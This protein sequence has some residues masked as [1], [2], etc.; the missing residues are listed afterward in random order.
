MLPIQNPNA[1]EALPAAW[2]DAGTLARETPASTELTG[3]E[4]ELPLLDSVALWPVVLF[5]FLGVAT[6]ITAGLRIPI[7]RASPLILLA[8]LVPVFACLRRAVRTRRLV[9]RT[10]LVLLLPALVAIWIVGWDFSGHAL[11]DTPSYSPDAWAYNA[12]AD[13]LEHFP[14]GQDSGMIAL[15]EFGSKGRDDRFLSSALLALLHHTLSSIFVAN[16][17]FVALCLVGHFHSMFFFTRALLKGWGLPLAAAF[18]S[19][20]I[21]WVCDA[22]M[23]GNY[24]NLL[25][26]TFC[27]A[28]LGIVV[29]LMRREPGTAAARGTSRFHWSVLP[30]STLLAAVIYAYPEGTALLA[31]LAFPLWIA[32]VWDFFSARRSRGPRLLLLVTL[33]GLTLLF[34]LPDLSVFIGFLHNQLNASMNQQALRPG[35]GLLPGLLQARFL[36]SLF[37]LGDE[38][39]GASYNVSHLLLSVLLLGLLLVG[40]SRIARHHRWFPWVGVVVLLMV[41]WMGTIKHYDYGI[42]KLM[43]CSCWWVYPALVAGFWHATGN[44]SARSALPRVIL[45]TL[46]LLGI[47]WE[48]AGNR[49]RRVL[50]PGSYSMNTLLDLKAIPALVKQ[51]P[52]ALDLNNE[53]DE[54]WAVYYLRHLRVL[55]LPGRSSYLDSAA[56]QLAK[57]RDGSLRLAD[58]G[59]MLVS[60]FDDRALWHDARCSLIAVEPIFISSISNPPNG[61][62]HLGTE[63][64]F[65]MGTQPL[66]ITVEASAA[67]SYALQVNR[68][69]FGPSLPGRD[70][71]TMQIHD[72]GPLKT[73]VI[74]V[75]TH[76]IPLQLNQG[77]NIIV[78]HCLD[79]PTVRLQPNGDTRELLLALSVPYVT[80]I[81]NK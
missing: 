54:I 9:V 57:G 3:G 74:D 13:Y 53:L 15:D 41:G 5:A 35:E 6:G 29:R 77:T 7:G 59:Y 73:I 67:G 42:Y 50:P 45:A 1:T 32:F 19:T 79:Q 61:E 33:C 24:D 27:P 44:L 81:G 16:Y 49:D 34:V 52:V 22:V 40:A 68:F 56:G 26:V 39:P 65:W 2:P 70:E 25:F 18:L 20:V 14:R 76:E 64:V 60:G 71:R 21:G 72:A 11:P 37:A 43:F 75:H 4:E 80:I 62:D 58:C 8:A 17:L 46:L 78:L 66:T 23:L 10:W 30:A 51:S 38:S 55:P 47:G 12:I 31:V 48:R 36:P 69:L 63:R 28:L